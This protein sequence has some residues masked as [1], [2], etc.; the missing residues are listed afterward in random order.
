MVIELIEVTKSV[1]GKK[2][3]DKVSLRIEEGMRTVIIGPSG[4]GKTT[5]LRLVVGFETVDTGKILIDGKDA[6]CLAPHKRNIGLVFQDLA[7]WPHMTVKENIGF[8]LKSNRRFNNKEAQARIEDVLLLVDL[9][10]HSNRY[11]SQLSG[12]E[13]QRVALARAL[14]LQPRILLLDE[15]LSNLDLVLREDLQKVILSLQQKLRMTIVYVTHNQ[16]EALAMAQQLA[17]MNAGRIEQCAP[18]EEVRRRPAT[19]FVRRFL[20]F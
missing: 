8:G 15:P 16:D 9:K 10:G 1:D 4:S 3:I 12:G 14:I 5:L 7:L 19:E 18:V 13:Q 20:K 2:I 17:V 11:P 6:S